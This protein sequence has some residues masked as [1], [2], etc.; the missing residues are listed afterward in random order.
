MSENENYLLIT[1]EPLNLIEINKLVQRNSAGAI[2]NFIGT[3]RDT[4]EGKEVTKLEYECYT[5]MAYKE[6]EKICTQA[7]TKWDLKGIAV[8]H[9]IGEVPVGEASVIISTSSAHRADS[10]ASCTYLIDTLKEVVPIWKKE[11]YSDGSSNWKQNCPGCISH[12]K[13]QKEHHH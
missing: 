8:H 3:T 4:F 9:R 11:W 6:L 12:K 1:E 10:L 7:R 2:T 5:P 13:E